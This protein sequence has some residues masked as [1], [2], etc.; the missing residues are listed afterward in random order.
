MDPGKEGNKLGYY[1]VTRS[2]LRYLDAGGTEHT[3]G[4]TSLISWRGEW[5]VVHLD[6]FK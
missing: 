6:G 3:L 1:R 2:K 5:F 4:L